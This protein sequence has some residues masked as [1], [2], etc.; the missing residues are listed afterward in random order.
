[1][2]RFGSGCIAGPVS[3]LSL[4]VF[5]VVGVDVLVSCHVIIELLCCTFVYLSPICLQWGLNKPMIK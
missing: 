5:V 1:M 4:C 2:T 3:V